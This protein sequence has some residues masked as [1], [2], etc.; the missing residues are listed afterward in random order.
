MHTHP[1]TR[2]Q[3]ELDDDRR[4]ESIIPNKEIQLD[5]AR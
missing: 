4:E 1:N 2:L 5:S 3:L